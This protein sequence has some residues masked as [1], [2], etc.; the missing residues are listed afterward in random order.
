MKNRRKPDKMGILQIFLQKFK[1][2]LAF[3][4][5]VWY[6]R[7]QKEPTAWVGSEMLVIGGHNNGV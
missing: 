4:G 1:I 5:K 6:N 2:V 3:F 7:K